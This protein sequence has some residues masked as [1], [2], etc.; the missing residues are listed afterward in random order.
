MTGATNRI[1][2]Y[3]YFI[4]IDVSKVQLDYAVMRDKN[5]LFHREAKNDPA[6]IAAFI[7]ELK[8]LPGFTISKSIFCMEQTGFYCNHLLLGLKKVKANIVLENSLQIKNSLG[9]IRGKYDKVDSIRIAQY[10][11]VRKDDLRFWIQRRPM[12]LQLAVLFSLRTRMLSL[13][14][15]IKMPLKEQTSFVK[16]GVHQQSTNLCR[17]S[18]NAIKA[19]LLE[20]DTT[21]DELIAADKHLK[22]LAELIVSVPNVGRIT[23]IQI[24][25]STNEFRDI[26]CPKKFAC[27]AGVA[28]FKQESGAFKGKGKISPI[29]NRKVKSLLHVCAIGAIQS[30]PEIKAYY[31][32][33]TL[34]EGKAKMSVV[35]A[36][37]Y[38]LILRVFA[39]LKQ[40]RP[41]EKNYSRIKSANLVE[42]QTEQNS[43]VDYGSPKVSSLMT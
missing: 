24:I 32:R 19:D 14:T 33:K 25:I 18:I 31:L 11:S 10:A 13:Q 29:A 4:G 36:V 35:N 3:N 38:K 23:A 34:T 41:Y 16:K 27:Y 22:R 15:A 5:L 28:P 43:K 7:A 39:C 8:T 37:R 17:N 30:D 40:D 12:I 2:K 26:R 21:M 20:I 9:L 42:L 1:K 6:D